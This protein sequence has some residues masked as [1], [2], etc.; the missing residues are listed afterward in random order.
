MRVLLVVCG[1]LFAVPLDA[2]A[3]ETGL[4]RRLFFVTGTLGIGDCSGTLCGSSEAD[5]GPSLGVGGGFFVRPIPYFAAGAELHYNLMTADDEDPNRRDEVARTY[6]ANLVVRGILPIGI[7]EPWAGLGF[8]YS[9]F[10][11]AWEK[12]KKDEDLTVDGID[13]AL[14]L[15]VDFRVAQRW[16]VGATMRFAFPSWGERCT[17][18]IEPAEVKTECRDVDS[19]E[20]EDR[21]ELPDD[22]WYVGV[23]GR[24]EL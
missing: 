12:E 10:G 24:F 18:K 4:Q 21:D 6:L 11:Y 16:A 15:G 8:G 22:V 19:L 23:T 17:R 5:T 13:V 3:Q 1:F 14:A 20:P 2:G 7:A 9:W